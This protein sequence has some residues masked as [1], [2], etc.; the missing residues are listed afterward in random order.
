MR[1][2]LLNR[3]KTSGRADDNLQTIEKRIKTFYSDTKP[4]LEQFKKYGGKIVKIDGNT[5]IDRVAWNVCIELKKNK[6]I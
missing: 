3:G 6:V 4:M 5:Y 2:R 1:N